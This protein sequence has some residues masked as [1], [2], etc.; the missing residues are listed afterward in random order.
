MTDEAEQAQAAAP[1]QGEPAVLRD[2]DGAVFGRVDDM[3]HV[4]YIEIFLAGREASTGNVVAACYNTMYTKA[5]IPT[6]RDTA[7]QALVEGLDFD[8]LKSEHGLLA[9]SLNGPKIWSQPTIRTHRTRSC[10]TSS[11]TTTSASADSQAA[12]AA[13]GPAPTAAAVGERRSRKV[14]KVS[15]TPTSP[16]AETR[17]PA[18]PDWRTEYAYTAGVQAFVYGFP[19]ISYAQLRHADRYSVGAHP[20]TLVRADDGGITLH[21]QAKA[22]GGDADANWLPTSATEPWFLILRLYRPGHAVLDG[23]WHCPA[24]RRVDVPVPAPAS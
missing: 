3:R 13:P 19:Y 22:P 9:A 24:V 17:A 7:P 4:R 12:A 15:D 21:L 23:T 8:Q 2:G 16:P 14:T 10:W 1:A 5:G 18:H 6:T 20:E 11:R